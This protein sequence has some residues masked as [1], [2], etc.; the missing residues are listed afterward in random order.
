MS[1]ISKDPL[2]TF[3]RGLLTF[4]IGVFWFAF[5]TVLIGIGALFT[6]QRAE[7]AESVADADLPPSAAWWVIAGVIGVA[8]VLWLW[9]RFMKVLRLTL[10]SVN[11]EDPFV[12]ENASRLARMGWIALAAQVVMIP[13]VIGA[14]MAK[15]LS[16]GEEVAIGFDIGGLMLVLTLFILSRIFKRG[17]EMRAELEGTV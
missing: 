13:L 14:K 16:D 3:A 9:L 6:V 17:A 11:K 15:E 2:L 12:E 1:P 8:V 4:F 5:G 10:I 7:L